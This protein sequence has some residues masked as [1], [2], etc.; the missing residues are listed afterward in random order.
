MGV[1]FFDT[2]T[3]GFPNRQLPLDH[4]DQPHVCQIGAILMDADKKVRAEINLIIKPDGWVIPEEAS[5]IHGITQQT[6]ER[7]GVAAKGALSL[8]YRLA[9]T[10][11]CIVAHNAGFDK[12]LIEIM[13][14]RTGLQPKRPIFSNLF[15]TMQ[16]SKDVLK[17][18]PTEKMIAAG[19]THYKQ[20]NLQE[21]HKFFFGVEF[22]GAH[23]AMADVRACRDIYYAIQAMNNEGME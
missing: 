1:L 11:G 10:A 19:R 6:A 4:P 12:L 16:K 8:F 21:A 18:P 15:C 13:G 22:E 5:R 14:E 3:T 9:E 17:L 7:Y 2:E 23:D 20:P